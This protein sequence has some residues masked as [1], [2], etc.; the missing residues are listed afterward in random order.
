M[1]HLYICV[2]IYDN[3]EVNNTKQKKKNRTEKWTSNDALV[4][5]APRLTYSPSEY[6]F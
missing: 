1:T 4:S 5:A 2:C 6:N 3:I